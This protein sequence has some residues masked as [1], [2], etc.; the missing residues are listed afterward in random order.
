MIYRIARNYQEYLEICKELH[1]SL[2]G[3]D[4][5]SHTIPLEDL[6]E[7]EEFFEAT[8]PYD[9]EN[10]VFLPLEEF[11]GDIGIKP[12][13]HEYP[14]LVVHMF[15]SVED[16]RNGNTDIRLFEWKPLDEL[17][18]KVDEEKLARNS[19]HALG[20]EGYQE[21]KEAF[22]SFEVSDDS[23]LL[24]EEYL[25][26][27]KAFR[28]LFGSIRIEFK[29]ELAEEEYYNLYHTLFRLNP[30]DFIPN[31]S[32]SYLVNVLD[33]VAIKVTVSHRTKDFGK[34]EKGLWIEGIV[35][36]EKTTVEDIE[37]FNKLIDFTGVISR[38]SNHHSSNKEELLT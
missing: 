26:L 2:V 33:S 21:P 11:D 20:V 16:F 22:I 9:E 29:D 5:T 31:K 35:V 6:Q 18:L 25:E 1:F 15:D 27:E 7:W 17:T 38:T 13:S 36:N 30:F 32:V 34:T 24:K 14:V 23:S 4:E 10:D 3:G 28:S 8:L 37:H 19:T 12:E